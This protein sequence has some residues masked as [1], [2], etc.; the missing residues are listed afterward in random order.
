MK[1]K[2]IIHGYII[3]FIAWYMRDICGCASH[4]YPYGDQGRYI[5]I[6]DEKVYHEFTKLL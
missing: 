3:D 1:I 5:V 2:R 4:V 6:M